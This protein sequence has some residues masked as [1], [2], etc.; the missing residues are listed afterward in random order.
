MQ[1]TEIK[2][3][4][5]WLRMQVAYGAVI[6][7]FVS[8]YLIP[9]IYFIHTIIF[10]IAFIP[11]VLCITQG[12][13]YRDWGYAFSGIFSWLILLLELMLFSNGIFKI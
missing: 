5:Y 4:N 7:Y 3:K 10:L 8:V 13:R 9:F 1:N 6:F 2:P 11:G 12:I